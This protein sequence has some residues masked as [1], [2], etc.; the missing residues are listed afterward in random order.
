MPPCRRFESTVVNVYPAKISVSMR[1]VLEN[2]DKITVSRAR[3]YIESRRCPTMQLQ[4]KL[5]Q[6]ARSRPCA[7][8]KWHDGFVEGSSESTKHIRE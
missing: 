8:I 7:T 6:I 4:D 3:L 2:G 1:L 5:R